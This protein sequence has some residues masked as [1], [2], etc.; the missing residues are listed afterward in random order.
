MAAVHYCVF[1]PQ[2]VMWC[3]WAH[4]PIRNISLREC[5]GGNVT[6]RTLP[7]VSRSPSAS[8]MSFPLFSDGDHFDGNVLMEPKSP[9]CVSWED[10]SRARIKTQYFEPVFITTH[11]AKPLSSTWSHEIARAVAAVPQT[12]SSTNGLSLAKPGLPRVSVHATSC[13]A[14][15]LV[16]GGQDPIQRLND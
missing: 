5:R 11:V 1:Y 15:S 3:A 14:K 2:H 4:V 6:H 12:R 13:D 16:N 9:V 8:K 10:C 7:L